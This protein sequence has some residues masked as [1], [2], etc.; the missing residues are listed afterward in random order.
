MR[1]ILFFIAF[2]AISFLS[3]AQCNIEKNDKLPDAISYQAGS[4]ELYRNTDLENGF[5]IVNGNFVLITQKVDKN[6]MK[7]LLVITQ[8][9]SSYQPVIVP[10]SLTFYFENGQYMT[11]NA[12]R[13]DSPIAKGDIIFNTC[14]YRIALN[15]IEKIRTTPLKQLLIADTRTDKKV[16]TTLYSNIFIEQINCLFEKA[17][18]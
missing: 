8:K 5:N 10:R 14:Y 12:D 1:K 13:Q 17:K 16:L 18:E 4:E 3:F 9:K 2:V 7:F 15:I 6:A 11:L